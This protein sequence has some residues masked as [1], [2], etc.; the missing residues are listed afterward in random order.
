MMRLAENTAM[1][2]AMRTDP[3]IVLPSRRHT[4]PSANAGPATSAL[5]EIAEQLGDLQRRAGGVVRHGQLRAAIY[6]PRGRRRSVGEE[7][8]PM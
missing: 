1:E 4:L 2:R 5:A 8:A 3:E 7:G 6:R